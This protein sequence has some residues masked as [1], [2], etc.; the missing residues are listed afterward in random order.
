LRFFLPRPSFAAGCPNGTT[1]SPSIVFGTPSS[2][3]T[4]GIGPKPTQ[5]EPTPSDH[6]T[7]I[8]FW[9]ARLAS[10]T[11]YTLS[12]STTT[13]IANAASAM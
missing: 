13:A 5:F 10:E 9:I 2:L 12:F 7:R 6:A 3:S 1:A 8:M 4:A 11:A